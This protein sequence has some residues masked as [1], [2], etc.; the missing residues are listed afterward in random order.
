MGKQQSRSCIMLFVIAAVPKADNDAELRFYRLVDIITSSIDTCRTGFHPIDAPLHG[1][2][3]YVHDNKWTTWMVELTADKPTAA[4]LHCNHRASKWSCKNTTPYHKTTEAKI[5]LQYQLKN[6]SRAPK[7]RGCPDIEGKDTKDMCAFSCLF[8]LEN[9][10]KSTAN[11]V[12]IK[13]EISLS[14]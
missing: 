6:H 4:L 13:Q 14:T 1:S 12:E 9:E 5:T 3:G 2:W 7:K 11:V 10:R 8:V